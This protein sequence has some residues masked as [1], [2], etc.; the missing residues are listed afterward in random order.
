MIRSTTAVIILALLVV[1][2]SCGCSRNRSLE[3]QLPGEPGGP[4]CCAPASAPEPNHAGLPEGTTIERA[5][6]TR[7]VTLLKGPHL[8]RALAQADAWVEM[9]AAGRFSEAA[10][11]FI[12]CHRGMFRLDNP[13]AELESVT[14]STDT[15]GMHHVR[16]QQVFD[17]I[18]VWGGEISVHFDAKGEIYLV[19]GHYIPTPKGVDLAHRITA[20]RAIALAGQELNHPAF[21]SANCTAVPVIY[22]ADPDKPVPAFRVTVNAGLA[23]RWE[24]MI[25][26]R[27]GVI[28]KKQSLIQTGGITGQG[29][30]PEKG[31]VQ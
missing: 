31:T 4:G 11:C 17:G 1:C 15:L 3:R 23:E 24:Y 13:R 2:I 27:S 19:Q 21:R 20:S 14:A 28:L 6:P 12:A 16:L 7:T 29:F 26:A 18:P 9:Q 30:A 22:A 5:D 10:V 8:S 25:H